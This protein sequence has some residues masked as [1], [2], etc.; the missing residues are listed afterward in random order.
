MT[1]RTW[2]SGFL[3]LLIAATGCVQRTMTIVSDPPGAKVIVNNREI[4]STPADVPTASFEY[5]GDYEFIIR[6]DG[7]EPLRVRQ[8]V[9]PPWYGYPILD[10]VAENLI[11]WDIKDHR[12]FVYALQPPLN[13]SPQ[14]LMLKAEASRQQ[15][16][17]IGPGPD[18]LPPLPTNTPPPLLEGVSPSRFSPVN[19]LPETPPVRV[20]AAP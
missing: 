1:T 17:V 8:S 9:P 7:Y 6:K 2:G 3:V 19:N 5:Y 15:A 11:P 13:V 16:Q 18:S 14:E 10:F 12:E 4:G 20:P